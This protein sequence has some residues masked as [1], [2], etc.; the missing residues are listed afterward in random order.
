MSKKRLII[1]SL[2][3][4]LLVAGGGAYALAAT[5][6]ATSTFNF[7]TDFAGHLGVPVATV[8]T[9]LQQT[10]VDRVN[11]LLKAGRITSAQAT[12]M[13][14]AIQSG[15]PMGGM[16][17]GGFGMHRHGPGMMGLDLTT[18][19]TYVGLTQQQLMT[20]LGNGQTLARIAAAQG[21][22]VQ[23][24]EQALTTAFQARLQQAVTSGHMTAAQSATALSQFQSRLSQMVNNQM[25]M[26]HEWGGPP[27]QDTNNSSSGSQGA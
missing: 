11:A 27:P 3:A 12:Q 22:T 4:F 23:G 25:K 15:K 1:G 21:K 2:T 20:D 24:L 10:Q 14:Q 26:G 8:K 9:A 13:E 17:W 18:V 5:G 7:L 6:S 19:A 16:G